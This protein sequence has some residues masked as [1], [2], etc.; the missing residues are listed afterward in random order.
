MKIIIIGGGP[1]GLYFANAM[2]LLNRNFDI[3]VYESKNESINEFGLG[4]TLQGL[5][6]DLLANLDKNYF[7]SLFENSSPPILSQAIVKTNHDC[8]SFKFPD[9]HCVSRFELMRF[10]RGTA[11][12]LGITIEETKVF[13]SDLERL[14]GACDLLIGADGVNS[15]VREKYA[16]KF[17]T[18]ENKAKI[19]FTWFYNDSET[20]QTDVRF[21][22]FKTPTGVIQLSSYPLTNTRQAVIIEMTEQC[23]QLGNFHQQSSAEAIPYLNKIFTSDEDKI[24]LISTNLPWFSFKMNT[25]KHLFHRNVALIGDAAFSFHYSAGVGL[26]TAFNMGYALTKCFERCDDINTI[27][28][29]Y[30]KM[31][32]IAL[33]ASI[34][35]SLDDI[36]WFENIDEH[37]LNTPEHKVIEHYLEKNKYSKN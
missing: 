14:Q 5:T 19:K 34:D 30:S 31:T 16:D 35:K 17:I 8:Q 24:A 13:P 32:P 23:F 9:G 36:N 1:A 3:I 26:Q 20:T 28:N 18:H 4:Y 27:L 21:Y 25:V 2:K 37:L 22:A 6:K 15:I 10:L 11:T 12:S 33:R 29:H 7:T